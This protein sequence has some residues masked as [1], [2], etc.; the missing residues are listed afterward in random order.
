MVAVQLPN[1]SETPLPSASAPQLRRAVEKALPLLR[2]SFIALSEVSVEELVVEKPGQG[3]QK[4]VR[5]LQQQAIP[6]WLENDGAN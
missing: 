4:R 5:R 3:E 6:K 1:A 2:N